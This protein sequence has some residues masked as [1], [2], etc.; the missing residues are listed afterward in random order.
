MP[1]ELYEGQIAPTA[2]AGNHVTGKIM[3]L[4]RLSLSMPARPDD[5]DGIRVSRATPAGEGKHDTR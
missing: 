1:V 3:S 2:P 5:S 4:Q